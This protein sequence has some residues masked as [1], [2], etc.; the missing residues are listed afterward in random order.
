MVKYA[1]LKKK[2]VSDKP[3]IP[4]LNDTA[5]ETQKE[6][7]KDLAEGYHQ[8]GQIDKTST[9]KGEKSL[10][11]LYTTEKDYY[12]TKLS[13]NKYNYKQIFSICNSPL[14]RKQDFPLSPIES[15]QDL[16]NDFNNFFIEK[17]QKIRANLK[18]QAPAVD[19]S[20]EIYGLLDYRTATIQINEHFTPFDNKDVIK[21]VKS[22]PSKSCGL[23]PIP[24]DLLKG[25]LAELSPLI[26][27]V[28]NPS[29]HQGIFPSTLKKALLG[30]LLKKINLDPIRKNYRLVSSLAFL[31]KLIEKFTLKQIIN[32]ITRTD[33][34]EEMQSTYRENHSTGQQ[35]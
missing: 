5:A 29:L 17:I 25:M 3:K 31:G 23:D 1:P 2:V 32:H 34:I 24:T 19:N 26:V 28:V 14:G 21:L 33:L 30:P 16:V 7:W 22:T 9:F 10:N 27:A 13:K 4:W 11:I 20:E 18:S 8:H 12:P 35:S 15:N 6:T